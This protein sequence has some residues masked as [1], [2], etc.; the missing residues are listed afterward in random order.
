[1]SSEPQ[2]FH[3]FFSVEALMVGM[4]HLCFAVVGVGKCVVAGDGEEDGQQT[5]QLAWS[6]ASA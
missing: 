1:M 3:V 5:R 2:L 6:C 4:D